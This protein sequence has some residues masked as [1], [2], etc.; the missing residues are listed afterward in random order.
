MRPFLAHLIQGFYKGIEGV[1]ERIGRALDD[2]L[3]RGEATRVVLLE[4]AALDLPGIRPAI[5]RRSS[6]P[7][8]RGLLRFRHFSVMPTRWIGTWLG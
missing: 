7:S 2:E 6:I 8:L 1:F 4:A 5:V 3:P